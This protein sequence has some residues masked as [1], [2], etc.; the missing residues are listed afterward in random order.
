MTSPALAWW[1][2]ENAGIARQAVVTYSAGA[3]IIPLLIA[4]MCR[5]NQVLHWKQLEQTNNPGLRFFTHLGAS[6]EWTANVLDA[7]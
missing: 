5:T 7:G 1:P 4:G 2:F 3:I 6:V